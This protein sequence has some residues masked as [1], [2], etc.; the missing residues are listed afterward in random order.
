MD[1]YPGEDL[2]PTECDSSF[3]SYLDTGQYR[4]YS[5]SCSRTSTGTNKMMS[6]T[7]DD[8]LD[9]VETLDDL[10]GSIDEQ[11]NGTEDTQTTGVKCEGTNQEDNQFGS[12]HRSVRFCL[13]ELCC[14]AV[15]TTSD[16]K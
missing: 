11:L 16:R 7:E 4:S 12:V 3:K 2:S 6:S 5:R 8:F 15:V 9:A 13:S 14:A 10:Q 1:P